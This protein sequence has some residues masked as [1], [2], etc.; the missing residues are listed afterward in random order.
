M[1]GLA[2]SLSVG[3]GLV[4]PPSVGRGLVSVGGG[5]VSVGGGLPS[6]GGGL[7]SV[8][9]SLPSVGGG[10]PSSGGG[11]PSVG[12]GLPSVGGG[13]PSVGSGLP[14]VGGGLVGVPPGLP[15]VGGCC[16]LGRVGALFCQ[17][18]HHDGSGGSVRLYPL[19]RHSNRLQTLLPHTD[20]HTGRLLDTHRHT[21][22]GRYCSVQQA[23]IQGVGAG[24]R[25]HPWGAVSPLKMN[26]SIAFKH[27]SITGRPPLG[28]ILYP[29]LF[30]IIFFIYSR[31]NFCIHDDSHS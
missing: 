2:G 19:L 11:L 24:A 15:V 14:S 29:P 28:E 31:C 23:R 4:G 18:V 27:Q 16:R 9:G 30:S 7:P 5:L 3:R 1:N 25:A 13:L 20:T 26:Y 22:I 17:M 10:L 12:G 6:V 8:G 21:D